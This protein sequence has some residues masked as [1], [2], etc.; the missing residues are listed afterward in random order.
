MWC[1][2]PNPDT[3]RIIVGAKYLPVG[4]EVVLMGASW[5]SISTKMDVEHCAFGRVICPTYWSIFRKPM[6]DRRHPESQYHDIPSATWLHLCVL[7]QAHSSNKFGVVC[8]GWGASWGRCIL[9]E[10]YYCTRCR[11]LAGFARATRQFLTSG[12]P[13]SM[14]S[15]MHIATTLC[16]GSSQTLPY[17][18]YFAPL[19]GIAKSPHDQ[20]CEVYMILRYRCSRTRGDPPCCVPKISD[21]GSRFTC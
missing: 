18:F 17:H 3:R 9:H 5:L 16:Y 10:S 1:P 19:P 20:P 6:A 13:T 8:E 14:L 21:L 4:I 11:V 12:L 15:A 2:P 7:T